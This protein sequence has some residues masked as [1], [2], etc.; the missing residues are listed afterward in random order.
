MEPINHSLLKRIKGIK[1]AKSTKARTS[2][3]AMLQFFYSKKNLFYLVRDGMSLFELGLW[4]KSITNYVD[5]KNRSSIEYDT[6]KKEAVLIDYGMN[7]GDDVS[8][9]HPGVVIAKKHNSVFVV[10]C[11]TGKLKG[12]YEA[13]GSVKSGYLIGNVADGFSKKTALVLYNAKW[14]SKHS[15]IKNDGNMVTK[16]FFDKL[17]E[18]LHKISL[19][20][21]HQKIVKQNNTINKSD[22]KMDRLREIIKEGEDGLVELNAKITEL[23]KTLALRDVYIVELEEVINVS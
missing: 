1:N 12:A 8:Y 7:V 21:Y 20:E 2:D 16:V 11:S 23:E 18:E 4:I 3:E 10:P 19:N 14:I 9:E 5:R 15:I 6:Q 22:K 13:N 17:T